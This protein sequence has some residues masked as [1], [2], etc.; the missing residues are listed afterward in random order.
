M[1]GLALINLV[2]IPPLDGGRIAVSLLPMRQSIAWSRLEPYGFFILIGL[3]YFGALDY[4]FRH[5]AQP[6]LKFLLFFAG[7]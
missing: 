5:V 1:S 2:P 3:L 4:L 7:A 6:I